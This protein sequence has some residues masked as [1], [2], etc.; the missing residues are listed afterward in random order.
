MSNLI[1][2]QSCLV[3]YV[4]LFFVFLL[5]Q[6]SSLWAQTFQKD[7]LTY[8]VIPDAQAQVEI[9]ECDSSL[10]HLFI[11]DS[12]TYCGKK[13]CVALLHL[14]LFSNVDSLES[15]DVAA[16]HP[17]FAVQD[18]VLFNKEKTE[19]LKYPTGLKDSLYVVPSTV[20]KIGK[21]AFEASAVQSVVFPSALKKIDYLAFSLCFSLKSIVFG[22]K[23]RVI[24][25]HS[26][27]GCSAL[28]SVEIPE[29]V[30]TIGRA[31]FAHCTSLQFVQLPSTV[32]Y[33][34]YPFID[35]PS[36]KEVRV[37][38]GNPFYSSEGGVLFNKDKTVLLKYPSNK[39]DTVY[40]IPDTVKELEWNAFDEV[41][42]LVRI[43]FPGSL[44][45]INKDV[46][47]DCPSLTT[48]EVSKNWAIVDREIFADSPL[49]KS[50]VFS[51]GVNFISEYPF[52][53]KSLPNLEY[54]YFP[55][56]L[57]D[58]SYYFW[59]AFH[60]LREIKVAADNP[61][62]TALDG[63]LFNKEITELIKYPSNKPD[64]IYIVPSTVKKIAMHAFDN[65][66][67]LK[68]IVLS[69]SLEEM[70]A[71]AF[72]G[73]YSLA[74]LIVPSD[75]CIKS[76][77]ALSALPSLKLRIL[78]VGKKVDVAEIPLY[79]GTELIRY[80]VSEENA[81][82]SSENGVL[83][84]KDKTRLIR[85]PCGRKDSVYVVPSTVREI[86]Q[87]AFNKLRYLTSLILPEGLEKIDKSSFDG[88][89]SLKTVQIPPHVRITNNRPF[90]MI[91]R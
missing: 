27:I 85:Y 35:C 66:S 80:E 88:C 43:A 79:W 91:I 59:I 56:T 68:S 77:F 10:K 14:P 63:V 33:M 75:F 83:F 48:L 54:L 21:K 55:A 36:L 15:F 51:E 34:R 31:A 20:R 72:S 19:L 4:G 70:D 17:F 53:F 18:G 24:G 69:D 71:S 41:K 42:S 29:G 2:N 8:E 84:N 7:G 13:Y 47:I 1:I 30:D 61:K 73:C 37:A 82:Y 23:L 38:K 62:Y 22:K 12:V 64:S 87:N 26:F 65:A 44:H 28:T 58:L 45:N 57:D 89:Y 5:G 11:P 49:L 52:K 39:A 60:H 67:K 32:S 9:V 74:R 78:K 3:R 76:S 90:P 16:G 46:F 40:R 81:D 86:D 6:F 50:I 25:R